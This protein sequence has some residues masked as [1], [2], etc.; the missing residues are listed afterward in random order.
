MGTAPSPR[1]LTIA[2][3]VKKDFAAYWVD[4]E[5]ARLDNPTTQRPLIASAHKYAMCFSYLSRAMT[6]QLVPLQPHQ[7]IF[8]Q[9]LTSDAVH[10]VHALTGGDARGA[11]FYL[12][13]VIEN[14]WRHHYFRDH[15]VEYG[16]LES[17][18]KYHLE[19]RDL[20]EH[21][22]W[23]DCFQGGLKPLLTNL[24]SL[25]SDLSNAVHS[26]SSKTMVLRQT[27]EDIRLLDSQVAAMKAD[28]LNTL[29]V[30]LALCLYSERSVYRGLRLEVQ[31]Y[32]MAA[33]S[34]NQTRLVKA[35]IQTAEAV[36]AAALEG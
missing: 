35:A 27:L 8:F 31:E 6:V 20:R 22:S 1:Q 30:C 34:V 9:E 25:Y 10:L 36:E 13:S 11:R 4:A 2:E 17:R 26:T 3:Q 12:R 5:K 16:W 14:F 19:M 32:L 33:L 7:R 23:L 18:S 24:P 28:V 29:K 15:V 21:C